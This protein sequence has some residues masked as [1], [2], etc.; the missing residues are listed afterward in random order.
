V[1][2]QVGVFKKFFHSSILLPS[3][4]V[5]LGGDKLV[6]GGF[7][8]VSAENIVERLSIKCGT[9]SFPTMFYAVA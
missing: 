4:N 2:E 1:N 9:N 8:W 6:V 3:G 5:S 7:R